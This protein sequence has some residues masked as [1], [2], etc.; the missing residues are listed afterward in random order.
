MIEFKERKT[1]WW[2]IIKLTF[3][4]AALGACIVSIY[5]LFCLWGA[6]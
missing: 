4:G 3:Q 2:E 5:L 1:N 6:V